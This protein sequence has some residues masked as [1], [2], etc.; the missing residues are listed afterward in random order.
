MENIYKM[1]TLLAATMFT[2]KEN[3]SFTRSFMNL[4]GI[5]FM[6]R[7]D[8][9][10]VKFQ[11]MRGA[12]GQVNWWKQSG[13]FAGLLRPGVYTLPLQMMSLTNL[14]FVKTRVKIWSVEQDRFL[15]PDYAK[16]QEY[17]E[18]ELLAKLL[19]FTQDSNMRAEYVAKME[20]LKR[21]PHLEE[22]W[23]AKQHQQ[24]YQTLEAFDVL[25]EDTASVLQL[26]NI[27]NVGHLDKGFI[28]NLK[29][30]NDSL[31]TPV[32]K[33]TG[34]DSFKAIGG[35]KKALARVKLA[36][37][38][39]GGEAGSMTFIIIDKMP[40]ELKYMHVNGGGF[41]SDSVFE[42]YGPSRITNRYLVKGVFTPLSY[43]QQNLIEHQTKL[44][45]M[46]KIRTKLKLGANDWC[47][48]GKNAFKGELQGIHEACANP[49]R[50][51]F[52]FMGTMVDAYQVEMPVTITNLV[53]AYGISVTDQMKAEPSLLDALIDDPVLGHYAASYKRRH[54]FDD[55]LLADVSPQIE[56]EFE[57]SS[58]YLYC[59][60]QINKQ[61]GFS[62]VKF[63]MRG[64]DM[65]LFYKSHSSARVKQSDIL[66]IYSSYGKDVAA[67]FVDAVVK[68]KR[69]NEL[70]AYLTGQLNLT[71]IDVDLFRKMASVIF[72][73][74][75]AKNLSS[76]K[77]SPLDFKDQKRYE[78]VI[79]RY[80]NGSIKSEWDGLLGDKPKLVVIHGYEFY[81]PS[82]KVMKKYVFPARDRNGKET[83]EMYLTGPAYLITELM[84][85]MMCSSSKFGADEAK[86]EFFV[87]QAKLQ[88]VLYGEYGDNFSVSGF[89]NK[90]ILPMYL[91]T[92]GEYVA[93]SDPAF[94]RF[95]GKRV[96][97][98]KMPIL[99]DNAVHGIRYKHLDEFAGQR[100]D[101]FMFAL[102][103]AV[104]VPQEVLL[105]HQNDCDGDM[106]RIMFLDVELPV[107]NK[108]SDLPSYMLPWANIYVEGEYDLDLKSKQ[109]EDFSGQDL[110]DAAIESVKAKRAIGTATNFLNTLGMITMNRNPAFFKRLR[111]LHAMLVQEVVRGVKHES[112]S[113]LIEFLGNMSF[114][115]VMGYDVV[116]GEDMSYD[117]LDKFIQHLNDMCNRYGLHINLT[118]YQHA[119]ED[120]SA[121]NKFVF[122]SFYPSTRMMVNQK[123]AQVLPIEYH[124]LQMSIG[125]INSKMSKEIG[126]AKYWAFLN[127]AESW[128][129]EFFM[130]SGLDKVIKNY[131][132]F[133]K[134]G[135]LVDPGST[136]S[137]VSLLFRLI[138][139]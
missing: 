60:D 81:I 42:K 98:S 106:A 68:E 114:K 69:Y 95:D 27:P 113:E 12:E 26:G 33:Q 108:I 59:I 40:D 136:G 138:W 128:E 67:M 76:N 65:G 75:K 51:K 97:F 123:Y 3:V 105:A 73:A 32:L 15:E 64:I 115:K 31:D 1:F 109:A 16:A 82:V 112:A 8:M 139:G 74:D 10:S 4:R 92:S 107:L 137:L 104:F 48:V 13:P 70:N 71:E 88:Q 91:D 93:C 77:I 24:G 53:V 21:Y 43:Q 89:A 20:T 5:T 49:R 66:N 87:Y 117:N 110:H 19:V 58:V 86:I 28:P 52:K 47:I 25:D 118:D 103:S 134:P 126:S 119:L 124:Y 116:Q 111:G 46:K 85:R 127:M 17:W 121:E 37:H 39:N 62:P 63:I 102:N 135:K 131:L 94:K 55:V 90:M 122:N 54:A 14:E 6:A 100:S 83:G 50:V 44:V 130:A 96:V 11:I 45:D 78:E 23:T 2:G 36:S 72:P 133:A 41:T 79:E 56:E 38:F 34:V 35:M 30:W 99:F 120:L 84:R 9:P 80:V 7:R 132:L 29:G 57:K 61:E 18:P 22:W 129:R 101:E 125:T